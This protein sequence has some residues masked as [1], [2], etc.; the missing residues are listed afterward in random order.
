ML[1]DLELIVLNQTSQFFVNVFSSGL[2]S[3]KYQNFSVNVPTDCLLSYNV[4][5]AKNMLK[6]LYLLK[7]I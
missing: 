4:V 3:K 7:N 2:Q 5:R 6:I 1:S